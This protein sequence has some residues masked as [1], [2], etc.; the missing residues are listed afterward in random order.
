MVPD[1]PKPLTRLINKPSGTIADVFEA[2]CKASPDQAFLIEGGK[3]ITY[4]TALDNARRA[5]GFITAQDMAGQDHCVASFLSHRSEALWGWLG[6]QLIGTI[7]SFLNWEHR[8]DVLVDMVTLTGAKLIITEAAGWEYLGSLDMPSVEK[9]LFVDH[10]PDAARNT[11][12]HLFTLTDLLS[13]EPVEAVP[14]RPGDVSALIFSSGSTGRSKAVQI[15]NNM[16][17]RGAA[18]VSE[19][20]GITCKDVFHFTN[21]LYH[22]VGQ[23]HMVM[24]AIVSGAT[25]ALYPRFSRSRFWDQVRETNVTYLCCFSN[26]MRYLLSDPENEED[27]NNTLR[28]ATVA[29]A[30]PEELAQFSKR[31]NLTTIDSYGMTEGEP[32]TLPAPGAMPIGSCGRVNKDFDVSIMDDGGNLLPVGERGHI[33]FRPNVPS[34]MM[35]GYLCDCEAAVSAWKDLWF[36]TQDIGYLDQ[37]GFLYYVERLKFTIRR[38]GENIAPAELE[39]IIRKHTDVEDC[40]ALGVPSDKGEE[41]IKLLVCPALESTIDAETIKLYCEG[42]VAKFMLPQIVEIVDTLPYTPAG[43][44]DRTR[45]NS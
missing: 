36:H 17:V 19:S 31:F 29:Q 25:L 37:D 8:G 1:A 30:A 11:D 14:M 9:I 26:V 21:P 6:C 2:R 33:V 4:G 12:F 42:R 23:L 18:R 43:K 34:I 22:I 24:V 44:I 16:I 3:S 5:A 10:I 38:K 39:A 15:P 20:L 41:D 40:V 7:H 13:A 27:V 45:L 35:Q 28:F 32:L